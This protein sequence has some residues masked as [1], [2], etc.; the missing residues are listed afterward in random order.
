VQD[1]PCLF[2]RFVTGIANL[3]FAGIAGGANSERACHQPVGNS[4][5][6][7]SK[8][9]TTSCR[10]LLSDQ[11]DFSKTGGTFSDPGSIALRPGGPY[12]ASQPNI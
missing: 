10:M 12:V 3:L 1:L 5:P 2:S 7:F 11:S 4:S 8:P 6:I 9:T